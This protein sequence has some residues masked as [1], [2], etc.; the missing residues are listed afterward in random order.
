MRAAFTPGASFAG[1]RIE[2]MVGR[3][4]MGVVYRATDLSLERPVAL[5]VIAPELSQDEHFRTRFLREPKLAASLDH[6]N[7]IPIYEAGEHDGEL[8]LAM[9]FVEGT[10][11]RTLLER[12]GKLTA[13]RTLAILGQ[14]AGAL[15]AAHRRALVHRDVK[16]A[17]VLIDGDGHAYLTDFGITKQ[18]GGASTDTGRMVGTLDYLAPEQI[19]GEPVDGRTDCYALGCVFY[20]CL[21]GKPPFRRSTE[22]ET[23]WAHMQEQPAA[24]RGRARLDAVVRKAVAKDREDRYG[25]C[26]ELVDEAAAALGLQKP[27]TAGTLI[28]AA[29]RR[30]PAILAAGGLVLVVAVVLA[31]IGLTGGDDAGDDPLGNGVAA[32]DAKGGEVTS[33]IGSREIPGNVAVG[34]GAVWVLDNERQTVARIDPRTRE[35][36]KKFKTDGVPSELAVG[37]GA[38]WIGKAGGEGGEVSNATV[39]LSRLDPDSGRVTRTVRLRGDTGVFP[40]AGAPRIAVGAGAVW[41]ANPD[42]SV[43]RI[44]PDSGRLEATIETDLEAFTIAAGDEGVWFL[45]SAAE[46]V[47]RIDPRTNKVTRTV[48]IGADGA[49][50][51]AVGAGS[52][53]VATSDQGLVWRIEPG[54]PPR[55]RTIDVGVGVSFV[56]FGEG[57][58]WTA[59]YVDGLVSRIN[60]R[61]N[62]VT[63]RTAIGAPQALA[64]GADAAWVSVAG[65][66]TDGALTASTCGQV[67]SRTEEPDVLLASDLPLQGPGSTD[68]RTLENAIRFAL[69]R[70][71]YRAGKYAVGYQSC[72]VSTPQTGGFEF[73]KCA[74]NATAFA[75][76]TKLVGVIGPWSSYCG[77]VQIPIM[78][79]APDGP[80]AMVSPVST[81]PGLTRGGTLVEPGALG[82][83]EEP[84]VYYPTGV[85][86][87]ARLTPREDLLGIAHAMFARQRGL[88]RVYTVFDRSSDWMKREHADPFA[89]AATR[90][91][92]EV[93]GSAGFHPEERSYAALVAKIAASGAEGVFVAADLYGGGD[94][95]VQALRKRLG[96]DVPMMTTEVMAPIPDLLDSIGAAAHGLYVSGIDV[97][98]D[99][100][101]DSPA[102]R[103]FARDFGTLQAPVQGVLPVAQAVNVM[104][105]AIARSDGTRR[106]VLE[107]LR[108]TR[109]NDG[110]LGD[111]RLDR[112]DITPAQVPIFRVTDRASAGANVPEHLEGTVVDRV[113]SVPARLAG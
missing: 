62:R 30:A 9:R 81:H 87:F 74:S 67:V 36:T 32:L 44:D 65:G 17:N 39:S 3:G 29:R 15:D 101:L 16:P 10:D 12:E 46:G 4:G 47:S 73:R 84:G 71:D 37:E 95:V 7:V 75:N 69:D 34:E 93:L 6:P 86:S 23:M 99:A 96:T 79:R 55:W 109:V 54:R 102:G 59:N 25:S 111:F 66:T 31:I 58:L 97:P 53:W 28:P 64:A 113:M 2:S 91:G 77:Q 56:S 105:D 90:L 27:T 20:E 103:A 26:V 104:L 72:D 110:Y 80:L 42:G 48:P 22:A 18:L 89:R 33:F 108:G 41:A 76:A 8:Y 112:G 21:T 45:G 82:K 14:V 40:V 57:A 49:R 83:E 52:V 98:P 35:V 63:A 51:V 19:R 107:Q 88:K 1:Y 60:P 92:M 94:R 61:T 38:I 50:G 106:S 85:R 13:E 70:R 5:K 11:L 68:P 78:N 100:R 24:I 43:S